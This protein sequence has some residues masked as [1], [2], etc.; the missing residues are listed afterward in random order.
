MSTI[1]DYLGRKFKETSPISEYKQANWG[2]ITLQLTT[3]GIMQPGQL[4]NLAKLF[5]VTN[6]SQQMNLP[7]TFDLLNRAFGSDTNKQRDLKNAF[8][9]SFGSDSVVE[10]IADD[11]YSQIVVN[12]VLSDIQAIL[13]EEPAPAQTTS[14]DSVVD[15]IVRSAALIKSATASGIYD[16][17]AVITNLN[18]LMSDIEKVIK[19]LSNQGD[20][21]P[22]D[23]SEPPEETL[24]RSRRIMKEE[25]D[26]PLTW[27]NFYGTPEQVVTC[28]KNNYGVSNAK[29]G[30][31][32]VGD[33]VVDFTY[34]GKSYSVERKRNSEQWVVSLD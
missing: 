25:T 3:R 34:K 29:V 17:E 19:L 27:V 28:L 31:S 8:I 21:T 30:N 10:N 1:N 11:P 5:G 4:Q 26:D 24:R 32:Y 18:T 23:T 6:D 7:R 14:V 12:E 13:E 16:T 9:K 33:D 2:A 20:S 22:A 15:H